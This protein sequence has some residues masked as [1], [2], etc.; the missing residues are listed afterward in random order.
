MSNDE[1]IMSALFHL[2]ND[3]PSNP[4]EQTTDTD[5]IELTNPEPPSPKITDF[6]IKFVG[7]SKTSGEEPLAPNPKTLKIFQKFNDIVI[8]I[9][10]LHADY[11]ELFENENVPT[12]TMDRVLTEMQLCF[13]EYL[14][15]RKTRLHPIVN[16]LTMC[17]SFLIPRFYKL[18][19]NDISEPET[20]KQH[21]DRVQ[22]IAA[23]MKMLQVTFFEKFDTPGVGMISRY[24][25]ISLHKYNEDLIPTDKNTLIDVINLCMC[26]MIQ[27]KI[28]T[29]DV[30]ADVTIPDMLLWCLTALAEQEVNILEEVTT[31]LNRR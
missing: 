11:L 2:G 28:P 12:F 6:E 31:Y 16:M 20:R 25:A 21:G 14:S 5:I 10:A 7:I 30:T 9:D 24:T 22:A 8:A 26:Q 15:N 29:V 18:A 3:N 1:G 19:Y 4:V 17:E 27:G 13:V 23:I